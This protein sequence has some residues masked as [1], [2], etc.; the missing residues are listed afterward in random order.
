MTDVADTLRERGARYGVFTTHAAI[1]Q[2]KTDRG[3]NQ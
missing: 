3:Q 2:S 1:T